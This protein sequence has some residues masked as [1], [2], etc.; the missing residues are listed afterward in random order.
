MLV[1]LSVFFAAGLPLLFVVKGFYW[2]CLLWA[3]LGALVSSMVPLTD[4]I[5][6]TAVRREGL[7]YG[8]MR[9]WGSVSFL[10]ASILGGTI[11]R[12][13]GDDAVVW[14]LCIGAVLLLMFVLLL[15]DYHSRRPLQS[16]SALFAVFKLP[17]FT[18]FLL[19]AAT[20]M[21]SHAALYSLSTVHWV[22]HGIGLPVIGL[23]WATGVVAEVFIFFISAKIIARFSPWMLLGIAGVTGVI[24]WSLTALVVDV[25]VLFWVQSLH[26]ITFTFTQLAVVNFIAREVPDELTASA[27]TIYD[28]CAIGLIFGL[29]LYVSGLVS[30]IDISYAFA[31][32]AMMSAMGAAVALY[33]M[34]TAGKTVSL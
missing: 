11:I 9:L 6:V 5:G 34:R 8:R 20:L 21:A 19:V 17:G 15:P 24:R 22:A 28:S 23:L 3:V 10:C 13:F 12:Y 30:R 33:V 18:V 26:A 27:Q 14:L 7:T 31:V 2:L 4:S 1:V 32:M 25:A 29:A 16:G